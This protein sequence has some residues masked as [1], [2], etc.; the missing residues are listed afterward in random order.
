MQ[1]ISVGSEGKSAKLA[2]NN[3]VN[4]TAVDAKRDAVLAGGIALRAMAK[5]GKFANGDD[6]ADVSNAIKGVAVSAVIKALDTIDNRSKKDNRY[7]ARECSGSD[8]N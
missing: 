7:R 6:D 4:V 3:A 5:D 8:E 2:K 1:A